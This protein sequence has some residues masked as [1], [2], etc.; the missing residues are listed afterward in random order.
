MAL[1]LLAS[2]AD[3]ERQTMNR[4]AKQPDALSE[5]A[6]AFLNR[7]CE[8]GALRP[9]GPEWNT[10]YSLERNGLLVKQGMNVMPT[11]AGM[12]EYR[13]GRADQA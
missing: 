1:A 9:T 4:F 2:R 3:A 11:E 13:R 10:V 6:R 12:E 7:L 8:D 5:I